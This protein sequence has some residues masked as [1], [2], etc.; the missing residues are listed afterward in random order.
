MILF[1][2]SLDIFDKINYKSGD[3]NYLSRINRKTRFK[4]KNVL[5]GGSNPEP[6]DY[7]PNLEPVSAKTRNTKI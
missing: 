4:S 5:R 3:E 7:Q 2:K 6:R 1:S